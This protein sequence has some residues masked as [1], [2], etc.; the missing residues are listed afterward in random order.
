MTAP[1][2]TTDTPTERAG[3]AFWIALVVGGGIMAFGI[4]GALDDLRSFSDVATWVIGADLIHDFVVAPIAVGIGWAVGRVVPMRWRAPIQAGLMATA[5]TVAIG[6]PGLRGYGR[7][8][9]PDNPS[10]QPLN[11]ATAVGTVIGFIWAV[12]AIWLITRALRPR[13][14]PASSPGN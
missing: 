13:P 8:L 1:A 6:W 5:I 3:A 4:R 7:H 12:V 14:T 11:S 10:V 2:K 9:V